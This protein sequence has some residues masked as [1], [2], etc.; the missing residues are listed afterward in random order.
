MAISQ[1]KHRGDAVSRERSR[2][3]G[4]EVAGRR[5]EMSLRV[6]TLRVS[7][8]PHFAFLKEFTDGLAC[9]PRVLEQV[10]DIGLR[11]H[12]GT[13]CWLLMFSHS[14]TSK[15]SRGLKQF[16]QIGTL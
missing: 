2:C 16:K 12:C 10:Q 14:L 13:G 6:H 15:N 4:P 8:I 5:S 7:P 9:G 11:G 1:E 3:K